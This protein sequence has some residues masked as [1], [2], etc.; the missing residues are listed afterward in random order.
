MGEDGGGSRTDVTL[1][2]FPIS[3]QRRFNCTFSISIFYVRDGDM[4]VFV[5]VLFSYCLC[6]VQRNTVVADNIYIFF[7]TL[8]QRD[9]HDF[10]LPEHVIFSI[11]FSTFVTI[12]IGGVLRLFPAKLTGG[13]K[14]LMIYLVRAYYDNGVNYVCVGKDALS[15]H[16]PVWLHYVLSENPYRERTNSS[17]SNSWPAALRPPP[18]V[19]PRRVTNLRR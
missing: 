15:M 13:F 8:P 12:L 19:L 11:R 4:S 6:T 5:I 2:I 18:L 16:L 3:S 10:D 1:R 17:W 9:K 14:R 7:S